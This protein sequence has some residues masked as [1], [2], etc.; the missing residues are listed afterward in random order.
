MLKRTRR[1]AGGQVQ[2]VVVV[3]GTK[4]RIV[5]GGYLL[6]SIET[7]GD[8]EATRLSIPSG[9]KAERWIHLIMI[10]IDS[11]RVDEVCPNSARHLK[12]AE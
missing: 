6:Q 1:R 3:A 4:I 7:S 11:C 8:L 9:K 12:N 2:V 5:P 10:L